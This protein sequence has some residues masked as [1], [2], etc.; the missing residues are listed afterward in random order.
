MTPCDNDF[1]KA[2]ARFLDNGSDVRAFAKLP[3][4]FGF[5]I[6]YTD[7]GMNLRSYYPDFVAVDDVGVHWLIET[8]GMESTDVSHKDSAAE[9]WCQNA[10]KL[11]ASKWKYAKIPQKAFEVLQ[12]AR[13]ADLAALGTRQL[14]L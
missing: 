14:P 2:F 12:P 7:E 9:N 6:D 13:L 11:T 3:Q 5:S 8:K 10:S 4:P 1:E